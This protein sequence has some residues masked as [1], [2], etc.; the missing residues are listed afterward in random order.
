MPAGSAARTNTLKSG[1]NNYA[2]VTSLTDT[3][4][5]AFPLITD[6]FST[7]IPNYVTSKSNTVRCLGGQQSNRRV[8]RWERSDNE[9]HDITNLTVKRPGHATSSSLAAAAP[10]DPWFDSAR[11]LGAELNQAR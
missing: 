10:S 4:N 7:T 6:G 9:V 11:K 3:S 8:L 5:P 2:Y 1:E